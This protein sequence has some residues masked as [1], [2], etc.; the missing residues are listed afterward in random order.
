MK[1][2]ATQRRGIIKLVIS[3]MESKLYHYFSLK[4]TSPS[5]LKPI[6]HGQFEGAWDGLGGGGREEGGESSCDV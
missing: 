4:V 6:R 5:T 2:S 1:L 3:N